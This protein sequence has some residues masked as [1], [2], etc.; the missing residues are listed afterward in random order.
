[1]MHSEK[2][3]SR[4]SGK[5]EPGNRKG[6]LKDN[7]FG[8]KCKIFYLISWF[9]MSLLAIMLTGASV[10]DFCSVLLAW[11]SSLEVHLTY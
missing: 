8:F 11:V 5:W 2:K 7:L 6:S 9:N 10:S 3:R 1:M 4:T